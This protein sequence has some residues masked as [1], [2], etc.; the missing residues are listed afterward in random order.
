L[1]YLLKRFGAVL[2]QYPNKRITGHMDI[3]ISSGQLNK[4]R[5][6]LV[7][8]SLICKLEDMREICLVLF[9]DPKHETIRKNKKIL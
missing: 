6:A 4:M 3:S 9:L 7:S 5:V 8:L 2:K 1:L